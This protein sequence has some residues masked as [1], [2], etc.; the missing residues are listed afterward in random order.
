MSIN[1]QEAR[2]PAGESFLGHELCRG[3]PFALLF[4]A[5]LFPE[6]F[7]VEPFAVGFYIQARA[8]CSIFAFPGSA[9]IYA[10]CDRSLF[11]NQII[12]VFYQKSDSE[13]VLIF[14]TNATGAYCSEHDAVAG[15]FT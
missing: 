1:D 12:A 2:A 9:G 13:K 14:H 7:F 5:V 11:G 15:N 3:G 6:Q 8:V 4:S 10:I